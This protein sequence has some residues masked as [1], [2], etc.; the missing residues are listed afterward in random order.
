MSDSRQYT[1]AALAKTDAAKAFAFAEAFHNDL[2][3]V[4][5]KAALLA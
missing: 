1:A 2:V 5:E 3:A 4:F